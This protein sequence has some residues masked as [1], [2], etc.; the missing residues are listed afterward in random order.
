MLVPQAIFVALGAEDRSSDWS[1]VTLTNFLAGKRLLLVIDNC[2]HL[3]PG[4]RD[5]VATLLDGCSQLTVLATSREPLGLAAEQRLRV[6]PLALTRPTGPDDLARSPAVAVFVDR[7]RRVRPDFVPG[8]GELDL[9]AGIVRGLDGIPLAIELAA[10]RLSCL[11]LADL[12]ARLDRA[13]DLLGDGWGATLRRTI[14]WSYDLLPD[15]ERRLFRHLGVFPDGLDLTA[16]EAVAARLG[17]PGDAAAALAHLVD[18]SMVDAVPGPPARYRLLDTV[19]AFARDRLEAHGEE[20]AATEGFADWALDLVTWVDASIDTGDEPRADDVLRREIANL[21]AAWG[22]I[23][24]RGRVDDAVRMVTGLDGAAG[25]RDLTEIWAWSIELGDDPAIESHP[26]ATAVLGI[27]AGCA[28]AR[29][30]L[31]RAE[32]LARQ[33]LRCADAGAN[34]CETALAMCALSRGDLAA[35]VAHGTA[36]AALAARPDESLGVAAVAAAYLGDL[37]T[38]RGLNDRL[39]AVATSPTL[40]AFH[41]YVAGEI[42]AQDGEADR[43]EQHYER[44]ITLARTSGA[45]F[46]GSVASVG[47][48]TGRAA[49]GRVGDALDGYRDLV[50][51]WERTGGWVQQWTTLRNLARLLR[52]LGDDAT[53]LFLDTVADRAPDAPPV[54]H[55][56]STPYE[57]PADR[58]ADIRAAAATA[59]RARVLDAARRAITRHRVHRRDA[60]IGT[61]PAAGCRP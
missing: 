44:A 60:G 53:A 41:H 2:E 24:G 57:L 14:E 45:T 28:W 25:W 31:D 37:D 1:L 49:A 38:A 27:A 48:L 52:T 61:G 39:A 40:E 34:R 7:A 22:L 17:L 54:G 36:A 19:Q 21:R 29:G 59:G 16:A 26:G 42:D 11:D 8:S 58:M 13:L 15:H 50:D 20:R 47:L 46:V 12:H 33:G 3:L 10:G 43:A 23:R 56:E 6:A 35:A 4:V 9:V 51:Y 30:E 32:R 55:G 5:V 18:A